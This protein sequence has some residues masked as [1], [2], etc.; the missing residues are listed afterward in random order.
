LSGLRT[1]L[2]DS[3][4]GINANYMQVLDGIYLF[5]PVTTQY[6]KIISDDIVQI[7]GVN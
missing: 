3:L 6:R 2:P 4:G 1:I 7:I 5:N